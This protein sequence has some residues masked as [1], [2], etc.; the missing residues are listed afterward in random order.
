MAFLPVY[1]YFN[2]D[3]HDHFYTT[4]GGEIGTTTQ[5]QSGNHGYTSEGASFHVSSVHYPG[6]V[7]IYRYF[8]GDTHDHFYTTN[9]GE[10]GATQQGQTGN[11]GYTCEGILGYIASHQI[12]GSVP[13]YR[14]WLASKNDHFYTTNAGEIGATQQGQ[15][16]NHG[17]T[18][19]GILGYAW[20]GAATG[21]LAPVFRYHHPGKH[22]HFYT[23]NAGEIGTTHHGQTGSNG[24]TSEGVSF[25]IFAHPLPGLVPVYRY[26]KGDTHDHFY[27]TNG[28]EIG[29]TQQGQTGNHGY[30]SEGILGYVSPTPFAGSVP[31]YRYWHATSND[32]FYTANPAEIGVTQQGHTGQ[33][34][35]ACEGILGYAYP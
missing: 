23:T 30:A 21:L 9:A 15:S 11:H 24:Y 27:T 29:V 6:L 31:V 13:V 17:Y 16:G 14:Y 35:Y 12:P 20:A 19:E 28:G 7:P 26:F 1:R 4:N 8:K 2:G 32:H 18:C 34:G 25:Q 5:G 3:K 22:D 33:H 10:I